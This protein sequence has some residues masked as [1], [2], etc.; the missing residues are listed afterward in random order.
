MGSSTIPDRFLLEK[1][2]E[3]LKFVIAQ[4]PS[5]RAYMD[6]GQVRI[7]AYYV[8]CFSHFD[9]EGIGVFKVLPLL[10]KTNSIKSW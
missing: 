6:M 1:A 4:S 9:E 7:I 10:N 3:D 8:N 5:L 2:K